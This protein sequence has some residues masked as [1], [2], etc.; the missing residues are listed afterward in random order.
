MCA[1]SQQRATENKEKRG[2]GIDNVQ[3]IYRQSCK[4]P[5]RCA[6]GDAVHRGAASRSIQAQHILNYK[7]GKNEISISH[8]YRLTCRQY[9]SQHVWH[10]KGH[11]SHLVRCQ[12]MHLPNWINYDSIPCPQCTVKPLPLVRS[13]Y[14][15][16]SKME[17]TVFNICV[18]WPCLKAAESI[19]LQQ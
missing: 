12:I 10:C 7:K 4:F 13:L 6:L 18:S 15:T 11:F 9:V 1:S 17:K 2:G 16:E 14:V 8:L 19:L 3:I 5:R